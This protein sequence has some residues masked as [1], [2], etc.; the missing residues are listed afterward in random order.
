MMRIGHIFRAISLLSIGLVMAACSGAA[1]SASALSL[2]QTFKSSD[3][4]IS[5][6]Y[7]DKWVAQDLQGQL[8]IGNSQA[9]LDAATPAPGMFQARLFGTP[10]SQIQGVKADATPSEVLEFFA[11]S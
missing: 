6:N 10:I 11:E 3:G 7:P 1:G 4:T 5:L 8:T 9:A 2:T